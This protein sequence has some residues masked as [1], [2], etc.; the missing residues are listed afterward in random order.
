MLLYPFRYLWWLLSSLWRSFGRPPPYVEFVL[1]ESLPAL[2][3]PPRPFWQRFLGV[4]S[5][6]S[7]KELGERFDAI[8]R[9][10]RIKGV[11]LHLRPTPT[12]MA[13]VQDL[14][15]LVVRLRTR[16]KRVV[17]WAP[18]YTTGSY[19]LACACDEILLMPGGLVQ[20]LGF[21]ST[22]VFLADGLAR[23]GIVADFVQVSPYKSAADTLTKSR[24]S[25][26]LRE[27]LTW[28]LESQH[29]ELVSA[30]AESRSMD[31]SGARELIDGSPYA[32]DAV[33][34][35]RVIDRVIAEED[36]AAHLGGGVGTWE[37]ASRRM[38]RPAPVLRRGRYVALIRVE[39]TIVDGRSARTPL[40]PPIDVPLVGD[41]RAGDLT[42]VQAARQVASDRRAAAVVL[43]VNSR[44]GSSTASE[45]M[46]LALSVVASRKP[47]VVV[48]GPVAASGGYAVSTP[49]AWIV[50]RPSTLTGSIGVLSGKIVTGGL[51]AKLLF[52]RETVA[53]GEHA[54]MESDERPFSDEEKA[55]LKR[56]IDHI[57]GE[58]LDSVAR[59]RKISVEELRPIAQ[60]KVW[61]GR[62]AL[63]RKLVDE[64]GGLDAGARKA[65][66]LA[67]LKPSAA[68]REVRGPK[69]VIPPLPAAPP[70]AGWLG[71]LME[72][73]TL[74]NRAPA[75]AVMEY[76]PPELV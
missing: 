75:L 71:Y 21:A 19:Y 76:L 73:L 31:E 46:R 57:Y 12:S 37:R 32:D 39:G 36:L 28:L 44:G 64:L 40:R 67:G 61:T 22:G 17:A 3:D 14:H 34:E 55:I 5:R 63:E 50:A 42:V 49:A 7:V 20:P 58:F 26:E 53:F 68:L 2:P 47:V 29:A 33:V 4:R 9:D 59:S 16:G 41:E 24:M 30:I 6:L 51:F 54:T 52:N 62:Q 13:G 48:M 11:V 70:A 38:R 56:E 43:Y 35:R 72:G 23:A 15:E 65:R 18:F 27:Q 25:P 45:A 10:R 66:Q 69:R 8:G 74:L 1:E 60:G